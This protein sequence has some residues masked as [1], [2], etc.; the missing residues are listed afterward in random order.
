VLPMPTSPRHELEVE[1][2]PSPGDA[3]PRPAEAIDQFKLLFDN[4]E[5]RLPPD[6]TPATLLEVVDQTKQLLGRLTKW[7]RQSGGDHGRSW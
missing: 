6:A 1:P 4:A 3:T 5:A 7:L 2:A